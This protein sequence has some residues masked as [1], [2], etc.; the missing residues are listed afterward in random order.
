[1]TQFL[2]LTGDKPG[3]E[4]FMDGAWDIRIDEAHPSVQDVVRKFLTPEQIEKSWMLR[5]GES[6]EPADYM[7]G[8][9]GFEMVVEEKDFSDTLFGRFLTHY[10]S[11][12]AFEQ[13]TFWYDI[14]DKPIKEFMTYTQLCSYLKDN[15]EYDAIYRKEEV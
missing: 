11:L 12:P 10:I 15:M 6:G 4:Q 1:M 9:I 8:H 2:V 13:L 14:G 5:G 7:A 3:I